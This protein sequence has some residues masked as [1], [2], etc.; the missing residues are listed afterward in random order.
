MFVSPPNTKNVVL[1]NLISL[2][3]NIKLVHGR[4]F[5]T[6]IKLKLFSYNLITPIPLFLKHVKLKKNK[7]RGLLTTYLVCNKQLCAIQH[8]LIKTFNS[9]RSD[10][11]FKLHT[12]RSVARNIVPVI[13][14]FSIIYVTYGINITIDM[15]TK[16]YN[17]TYSGRTSRGRH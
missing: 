15:A 16:K 5:S 1:L 11:K 6:L 17:Q 2:K 14:L 10:F 9:S 13:L 8:G 7:K 12:K 4:C 3:L